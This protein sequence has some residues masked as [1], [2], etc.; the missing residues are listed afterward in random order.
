MKL[1]PYHD[2]N[3]YWRIR[4]FLRE[5]ALAECASTSWQ[6]I[7]CWPVPRLDYWRWHVASW[8]SFSWENTL[9]LWETASGQ[10]TA[11]INP[12]GQGEAHFKVHPAFRS[13]ELECEMIAAAEE[14]LSIGE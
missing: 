11:V 8:Q 9:Y 1:R 4:A 10:I 5:A 3:D 13:A 6:S 7:T 12:E 2:E 14:Y